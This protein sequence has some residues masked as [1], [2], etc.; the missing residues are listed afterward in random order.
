M[1]VAVYLKD[2]LLEKGNALIPGL[3][4]FTSLYCAAFYEEATTLFHPPSR[5]YFFSAEFHPDNILEKY[6]AEKENISN[7]EAE[8]EIEEYVKDCWYIL[9]KGQR[10]QLMGVGVIFK[11]ENGKLQFVVDPLLVRGGDFYGLESIPAQ[12]H[13]PP[14]PPVRKKR[15]FPLKAVLAGVMLL[16]LILGGL[17]VGKLVNIFQRKMEL[18]GPLTDSIVTEKPITAPVTKPV[19][20]TARDS[21]NVSPTSTPV[22]IEPAPVPVEKPIAKTKTVP[23]ESTQ[24][25]ADL[26]SGEHYYI[27]AGCFRIEEGAKKFNQQLISKGYPS[28]ILGK[29]GAGLTMV[30]YSAYDT[31]DQARQALEKIRQAGDSGAYIIRH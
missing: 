18:R 21:V 19:D 27:L 31:K 3:G 29:T 24:P 23:A 10:L 9:N 28:Q 12:K 30:S 7:A 13:E 4:A 25:L 11:D 1:D 20:T 17:W 5:D 15:K 6:I 26:A 22:V 8:R 16:A 14:P 2:H